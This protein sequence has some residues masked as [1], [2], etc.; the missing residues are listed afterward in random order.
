MLQE[1]KEEKDEV[2]KTIDRIAEE[3]AGKHCFLSSS[4]SPERWICMCNVKGAC[5]LQRTLA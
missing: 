2:E 3:I 1:L 4:D 5:L